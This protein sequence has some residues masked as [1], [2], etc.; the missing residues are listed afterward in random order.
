[1]ESPFT[2]VTDPDGMHRVVWPEGTTRKATDVEVLLWKDLEMCH[3]IM[4]E[5][6]RDHFRVSGFSKEQGE[7]AAVICLHSR[8]KWSEEAIKSLASILKEGFPNAENFLLLEGG[9][10]VS[11]LSREQLCHAEA[12]I[13]CSP[14]ERWSPINIEQDILEPLGKAW[15]S[16]GGEARE[17][18]V[19]VLLFEGTTSLE[20]LT[21]EGK[22]FLLESLQANLGGVY[23]ATNE[24]RNQGSASD[25]V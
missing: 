12:V 14:K 7:S 3:S 19:P 4:R 25:E 20:C 18:G 15:K 11:L 24:S 6:L 9:L 10:N 8:E 16:V 23:R 22:Q 5:G 1:M 13:I 17:R 2:I 21:T